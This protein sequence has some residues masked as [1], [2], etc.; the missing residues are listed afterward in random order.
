MAA[1]GVVALGAGVLSVGPAATAGH[2][3]I[4]I[5]VGSQLRG[6]PAESMRFHAPETITVHTG[7][8]VSFNFQGFHTA[9][10]LPTGVGGDDWLH[11]NAHS[12]SSG[13]YAFAQSDP[14]DG[15]GEYKD[16]FPKVVSPTDA[17]C[18]WNDQTPCNFSG[19]DVMNS[20]APREPGDTFTAIVNAPAGTT[21]WVVCLVHHHMR[22]RVKVVDDPASATTQATID[23]ARTQQVARDTDWARATHVKFSN[24]RTSHRTANGRRV[25][26]AWAG[27]DSRYVSLYDFYPHNLTI[28]KGDTVRWRFDHLVMEDHTVSMPVPQLFNKLHFDDAV[29]DPDGDQGTQPDT[30]PTFDEETGEPTCPEGSELE[31]DVSH[32]FWGG[33]GNGTFKGGG[34]VEHSG[35][36]GTQARAITPPA[37]GE[38]SFDVK[39]TEATGN[40]SVV[41]ICFLHPMEG[42]VK[43]NN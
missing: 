33:D 25:W 34:D 43:V 22:M 38:D 1:V 19:N 10:L 23:A 30:Q 11:D 9:T 29:C 36:R 28:S 7:D 24:R 18:G 8:R 5:Q 2:A 3:A 32:D 35:I 41:Y 20:G 21:F 15:S 27:V 31:L 26:D 42:T 37:A 17:T 40:R 16:N 13:G 6:A 39:F 4:S 12:P 14:D